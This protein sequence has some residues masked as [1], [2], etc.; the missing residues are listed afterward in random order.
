MAA[1]GGECVAAA[2]GER[3]AAV[4]GGAPVLPGAAGHQGP[5]MVRLPTLRFTQQAYPNRF[6]NRF[7]FLDVPG[8][9]C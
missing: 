2:G 7:A 9:E 5:V 6:T 1:A 3:V 4:C 8:L